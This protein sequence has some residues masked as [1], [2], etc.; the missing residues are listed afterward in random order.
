M[1]LARREV[2]FSFAGGD[3]LPS[4]GGSAG[5]Q[6]FASEGCRSRNSGKEVR[7]STFWGIWQSL[8]IDSFC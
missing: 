1:T 6:G 5:L 7:G 2:P 8:Q 3:F 4:L